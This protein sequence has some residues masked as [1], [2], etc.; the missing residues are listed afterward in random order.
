MEAEY[1][2]RVYHEEYT[3]VIEKIRQEIIALSTR[4]GYT[5]LLDIMAGRGH[6]DG[7]R[8]F[9]VNIRKLAHNTR[10]N[11]T[12][13]RYRIS[14]LAHSV[15]VA[16]I[17]YILVHIEQELGTEGADRIDIADAMRAALYHDVAEAITGDIIAPTKYS[18]PGFSTMLEDVERSMLHDT[19]F[20][21]L[22]EDDFRARVTKNVLTPFDTPDNPLLGR[23]VKSADLISAYLEAHIEATHGSAGYMTIADIIYAKCEQK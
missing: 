20:S 22:P 1:N 19:L 15:I 16:Y 11:M 3:S 4:E 7:L 5:V 21:H 8:R 10:W 17:S 9:L 14:V 12:S 18:V 13:R 6:T 2:G 23:I